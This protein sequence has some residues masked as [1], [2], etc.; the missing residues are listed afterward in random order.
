MAK[1]NTFQKKACYAALLRHNRLTN[2][3]CRLLDLSN[4]LN[5]SKNILGQLLYSNA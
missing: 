2:S 5:L 3:I 1:N 4:N